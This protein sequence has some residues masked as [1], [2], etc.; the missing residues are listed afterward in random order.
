MTSV[1]FFAEKNFFYLRQ[2]KGGKKYRYKKESFKM[3][4]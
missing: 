1:L 3:I 2:Q 4:A